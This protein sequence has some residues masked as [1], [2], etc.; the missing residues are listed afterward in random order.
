MDSLLSADD[1]KAITN[2]FKNI[3]ETQEFEIMVGNYKSTNK[4][5]YEAFSKM[6][7]YLKYRSKLQSL[8]L[9]LE[10]TMDISYKPHKTKSKELPNYRI[11]ISGLSNINKHM[12]PIHTRNNHVIFNLLVDM[13]QAHDNI[14][15][16]KKIKNKDFIH[17][18]DDY[19][20]RVRMSQEIDVPKDERKSISSLDEKSQDSIHYRMKE[21]L[22]LF[23]HETPKSSVRIDLTKARMGRS[24][25][26]TISANPSYEIEV[27]IISDKPDDKLL[28]I[29]LE[30]IHKILQIIQ[31]SNYIVSESVS[32]MVVNKYKEILGISGKHESLQVRN[33]K[34]LEVGHV[35]DNLTNNYAITDKA[36]GERYY[37][38]IVEFKVFLIS[39]NLNVRFLGISLDSNLNSYN[40]TIMDG[41]LIFLNKHNRH[42]FMVFDCLFSGTTDVRNIKSLMERI[43][44]ANNIINQCFVFKGQQNF[45]RDEL[46]ESKT[47]NM[48]KI[49]SYHSRQID[50]YMELI[51]KDI[52]LEKQYPLI[53]T[54]YFI[55]CLGVRDNE[56]FKY[57]N[58]L[59]NKYVLDPNGQCPY[60]LDGIIYQPL[61]Q[62]HIIS[63]KESTFLDYKW[64]PPHTNSIDFYIV[65]D[66]DFKTGDIRQVFDNT[67]SGDNQG[68]NQR[69]YY[70]ARLHVGQKTK[71][72]E[73]PILFG[74]RE[75]LY[76]T[77]IYLDSHGIPRDIEG[78]PINDKTVVEFY[79]DSNPDIDDMQRWIPIRT[80]YDKTDAV[81]N[82]GVKYGNNAGVAKL[83]W[84][85]IINPV[86]MS[87]ITILSQDSMYSNHMELMRKKIN[88]SI[89]PTEDDK[90]K[91]SYYQRRTNLARPMR[92]FHNFI[93]MNLIENYCNSRFSNDGKISVLDI[94]C[95]IG[96]D[97]GKFYNAGVSV[98]VGIDVDKNGLLSNGDSAITRYNDKPWKDKIDMNFIHADG[99][100]ILAYDDQ[101]KAIGR[102]DKTNKQLMDRFFSKDIDKRFIFDRISCQFAFHYFLRNE[103][104]WANILENINMYLKNGG[105]MFITCFD[106]KKIIKLL[107]ENNG[108][109]TTHYTDKDGKEQ[110]LF[111]IVQRYSDEDL[112]KS[113][114][115]LVIDM[116]TAI[117]MNEGTF[118]P[119][120]LVEEE[121]L[122]SEFKK[123]C[124]MELVDSGTF[125][126]QKNI[127][128]DYFTKIIPKMQGSRLSYG[129]G[130]DS[131][132]ITSSEYY[133]KD[134]PI[135]AA[136]YGFSNLN[137]YYVFRKGK[138]KSK[139]EIPDMKSHEPL[140]GKEKKPPKKNK[141]RGGDGSDG[142][143]GTPKSIK[144][145]DFDELLNNDFYF[146]K[147]IGESSVSFYNSI[148][149]ILKKSGMIP[150][151]VSK[152]EFFG[153]IHEDNAIDSA[154]MKKVAKDIIVKHENESGET[155]QILNGVNLVVLEK[156]CNG[157]QECYHYG[158]RTSPIKKDK[159]I[160]LYRGKKAF[161]PVAMKKGEEYTYIHDTKDK[162]LMKVL[163][164]L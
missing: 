139:D 123:K 101:L 42:L 43:K 74:E 131:M 128:E 20:F 83:V 31:Q 97:M 14:E 3:S 118:E 56:V 81:I 25:N 160:M 80:R 5:S 130:L 85:S 146:N 9:N 122:I 24:Y 153:E 103:T 71:E 69:N 93:K 30:E 60:L 132:L 32:Y 138:S 124:K 36:D 64:K 120:Y 34:S 15:L 94:G 114:L 44:I 62:K 142:A 51:N 12:E 78:R 129:K 7:N 126:E 22:S 117:F 82:R 59:W 26:S 1:K 19:N 70:I 145:L 133:N 134:D 121:F 155:I 61:E 89:V 21:R 29:A 8:K 91:E 50:S 55:N 150:K 58:L 86:L 48:D 33:T 38:I 158:K 152:E 16:M 115:G 140:E 28:T 157:A 162:T 27:E 10:N 6:Q 84:E 125:E 111:D 127:H 109:F 54:K 144:K 73:K 90:L 102:M 23:V 151:S 164:N 96:G 143:E 18:V 11:T 45:I 119:E 88:Y 66:K 163:E 104:T 156:D 113:K 100:S 37:L 75:L 87:D 105:Y 99:S 135:N 112:K 95:G 46:P 13:E 65:F 136:C 161:Y 137:R 57:S 107:K 154:I 17:D 41:E 110:V 148:H 92:A 4:L 49:L 77:H 68:N 40:N 53:R 159:T 52:Q 141:Q 63:Q 106:A 39:M 76:T 2:I 79:Y 47:F 67:N 98:Y 116:H 149:M 108:R 72:G 35:V 147:G